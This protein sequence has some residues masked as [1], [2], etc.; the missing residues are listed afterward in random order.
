MF[1]QE[2]CF[3][4]NRGGSSKGS[5]RIEGFFRTIKSA[6]K[7]GQTL[8]EAAILCFVLIGFIQFILMLA[9]I[10]IN[11]IWMEH[12]LYQGVL[13]LAQQREQQACEHR[14]LT[15]VK[16]LNQWAEIS[17]LNLQPHKGEL[18]WRFY[19]KD[20]LIKQELKPPL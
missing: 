3:V 8:I 19:N 9:W 11:L 2:R 17:S 18:L 7:K 16:K 20:F 5:H 6:D 4:F 10:F 15:A 13:C 1:K 14:L 12:Q